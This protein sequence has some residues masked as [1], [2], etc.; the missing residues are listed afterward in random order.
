MTLGPLGIAR[1]LWQLAR[2]ALVTRLAFKGDYWQWRM[3][4]A[5]GRGQ[6]RSRLALLHSVL[7]YGLWVH[8][9]RRT[10]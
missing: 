1:S 4:T 9:I 6:P 8:H 2:L 7:E 5:F 10:P 3:H